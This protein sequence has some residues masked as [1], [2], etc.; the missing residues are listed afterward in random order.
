[1]KKSLL[2][3]SESFDL[4]G[5]ETYIRGEIVELTRQGWEVHLACGRQFSPTLLPPEVG[6]LTS[7]LELGPGISI[8]TFLQ[9]VD[10]LRE[11]VRRNGISVI[12]AHPFS[13]L[14][15]A[16]ACAEAEQLPMVVTLH[17]P[18]S[19]VG[20]Y[21]PGYDFLNTQ[22]VLPCASLVLAVSD[23]V[24]QLAAPYREQNDL[25]IQWNTVEHTVIQPGSPE[26]G[27]WLLVSRL[28]REKLN[29][30]IEFIAAARQAGL[31]GIDIVGAGGAQEELREHVSGYLDSGFIRLLGAHDD[32]PGL[33]SRYAGVAG[34]GR[35]AMEAAIQGVPVCLC[36]YDGIKGILD[37]ELY[38][39]G[40]QSNLSGR[41]LPSLSLEIAAAALASVGRGDVPMVDPG[42][43]RISHSPERLWGELA[44]LLEGLT[45]VRSSPLAALL[46][47]LRAGCSGSQESAYWSPRFMSAMG[48]VVA[49][50]ATSR[51]QLAAA[52]SI[53]SEEF[54][55]DAIIERQVEIGRRIEEAT[56]GLQHDIGRLGREVDRVERSGEAQGSQLLSLSASIDEINNSLNRTSGVL[57]IERNQLESKMRQSELQLAEVYASSSWR[58]TMPLRF[59][60]R[61]LLTPGVA[62]RQVA[63][64]FDQLLPASWM[65]R[66]RSGYRFLRRTLR[67]GRIDPAD[68]ARLR[69]MISA[70]AAAVATPGGHAID[71]STLPQLAPV[72]GA[73]ADVFIWAVIDWSFRTQRPQHLAMALAAKGHRVFYISNNFSDNPVAGFNVESLDQSGRLF[74]V[75]LNLAGAPQ[76]YHAM[77]D[78]NQV[79]AICSSVAALLGWTRSIRCMSFV[80]HP[81][82]FEPAQGLPNAKLVYDCMDHHGGFEDNADTILVG[83]R[84]LIQRSDLLVVT[85]QWLYDELSDKARNIAMVRNATE[86]SH[87]CMRPEKVFTDTQ[88]R[89]VIGYY[90]AIAEW[91]DV[92]LLRK[93]A[94]DNPD[95]LVLMIGRDTA[96]VSGQVAEIENIRFVGEIAYAELPF[97]LHGF[98]VCLL[99]FRVIPLTLAT[100]PVKVY[101]Y[102]SA[103]KAVVSVDLPELSQFEGLVRLAD[104][105][106]GF[107]TQVKKALEEGPDAVELQ[108]K[109]RAF[110]S[111]QTWLH[112]AATLDEALATIREPLISVVVLT[113]NNLD[114]TKQ[115]LQSLEAHTDY[116]DVEIIVVDNASSDGSPAY[117][118]EWAQADSRR[119]FIA[120]EQNLGFSAGNNVG[121]RIARG[122][123][124]VVLNNDT[125]VT[126]GWIRTLRNQLRRHPRAGLAGPVT[127]NIGN[128][129][130][131]EI[132]YATMDEMLELAGQ[133]TRQH[134]GRSLLMRTCAF[135]CVMITRDAYERIGGLDEQFGV[136][137]F[138]D[139][140]YCRRLEQEGFDRL[141]TEDV[142]VHHHLSA[143]FNKLKA[144]AKQ[145]LFEKN[146]ALYEAKWG[147]W[148]AHGY[149][150]PLA[151]EGGPRAG[152]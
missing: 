83:E 150:P 133:Y 148:V 70:P 142:F 67:S 2:I 15:P 31:E 45:P 56:A 118:A 24:A 21:G 75:N 113:Y 111:R 78:T 36:G 63:S 152:A 105:H 96:G 4:G 108:E 82:W 85:S 48:R 139:D 27:R 18:S 102:L 81:Y 143:S 20:S 41:G 14:I 49:A 59:L 13:S 86:F 127:N 116:D 98:D 146:K 115:C 44:A 138:E 80:Q 117:L 58:L 112:R 22:L 38:R 104:D 54:S 16:L 1:M 10:R 144:E 97:W 145:A 61:I 122:D 140:D 151:S 132:S 73:C 26:H 131:I 17:G 147:P 9:T 95:A 37:D 65:R 46:L 89:R 134:A 93:V 25:R 64:K 28:D 121:L 79:E 68:R 94:L 149:R 12:H 42:H 125:Y 100:N 5:V 114:Y 57:L 128:E 141:C 123:Y 136:G 99:P 55:R 77:P 90:G 3:V 135:F 29:G 60:K 106:D 109:R 40:M 101:E 6:S 76:I 107:L 43:L 137:F 120:N 66:L 51:P 52:Y 7:G 92:E 69:R 119:T 33:V 74:Q 8:S 88:G 130:K 71:Y 87:F 129:A 23:E 91:F 19:V 53:F 47:E 35:V 126:P 110:A 30:I 72:A 39:R 124:L 11:L 50:H 34:M 32:V 62:A 84:E 103:G